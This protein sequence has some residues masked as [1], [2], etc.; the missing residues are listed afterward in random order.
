MQLK[1]TSPVKNI[2]CFTTVTYLRLFLLVSS[3]I[4]AVCHCKSSSGELSRFEIIFS[5]VYAILGV[6]KETDRVTIIGISKN[7]PAEKMGLKE[8]DVI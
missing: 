1:P 4:Y 6:P 8:N 5:V 7:S 2:K 3:L